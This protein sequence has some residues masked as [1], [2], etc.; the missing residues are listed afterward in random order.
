M[1]VKATLDL[2]VHLVPAGA[3]AGIGY[4]A[5]VQP[6]YCPTMWVLQIWKLKLHW[7]HSH[8]GHMASTW[9]SLDWTLGS[10]KV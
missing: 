1:P 7:V 8:E 3:Q 5:S 6:H 10:G 4:W 9:K 2:A